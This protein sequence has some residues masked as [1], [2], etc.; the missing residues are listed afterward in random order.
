M[1]QNDI[2][3]IGGPTASGKSAL[4]LEL[5]RKVGGVVINADSM[6]VY[7]DLAVLTSRPS[8]AE[9][10]GVEHRLYG[11]IDGATRCSAALWREMAVSEIA[12]VRASG[13][14]PILVGGTGL[15]F[16]A[17]TEGLADIPFVPEEVMA[18]ARQRREELGEAGF[19]AEVQQRD[20]VLAAG[21]F[22][23]DAQRTLRAWS[24]YE[25]TGKPLSE[26]LRKC[27]LEGKIGSAYKME[28]SALASPLP[29]GEGN[30][31]S[32]HPQHSIG[33]WH[34]IVTNPDRTKLYEACD[35]R[36]D[37]MLANGVLDE[38]KCLL[39]RNLDP[40]LP[41]MKAVGVPEL[42][43]H[44]RGEISLEMATS[45][46]KQSTRN[47]AKRQ[48]TWFKNQVMEKQHGGAFVIEKT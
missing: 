27:E 24:V 18:R 29:E 21:I 1:K 22:P 32:E 17:L 45:K 42:A 30:L 33:N 38:V 5:A 7:A 28:M 46:A 6:Q 3:L 43:A 12:D 34:W 36:F 13:K 20:P 15:Y 8:A 19:Y 2:I 4:A 41:I 47:Y 37:T 23:A 14:V 40:S 11:V 10:G 31:E 48:V 9:M 44:I 35:R 39:E 26:W 16:K 25:A